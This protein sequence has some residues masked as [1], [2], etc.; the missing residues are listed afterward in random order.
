M[1]KNLLTCAGTVGLLLSFAAQADAQ[2]LDALHMRR[3]EEPARKEALRLADEVIA[4]SATDFEQLWRAARVY[5]WESDLAERAGI[6][7]VAKQRA[8]QC[9]SV[10]DAAAL[11]APTR[12][13]G[14][15]WAAQG[16]GL[17]A[18]A[19]GVVASIVEGVEGKFHTRLDAALRLDPSLDRGSAWVLRGAFFY[20]VPWPKRDLNRARTLLSTALE[21]FPENLRARL[22]L[23]RIDAE[24]GK[25]K[26]ALASLEQI[27]AADEDYDPPTARRVK[28]EAKLLADALRVR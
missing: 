23:A 24:G 18:H 27:E 15:L 2:R 11:L 9:W 12:A 17:W 25:K 16:V 19:N 3:D 26:Q 7:Q 8:Q 28:A 6:T 5:C 1:R 13:E 14:F 4:K 10:G 21:R 20:E 22:Y